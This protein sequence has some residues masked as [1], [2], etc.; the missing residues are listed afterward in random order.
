[1]DSVFLLTTGNTYRG[2][3]FFMMAEVCSRWLVVYSAVPYLDFHWPGH[4]IQYR[5]NSSVIIKCPRWVTK[6][7][8]ILSQLSNLSIHVRVIH[9][10]GW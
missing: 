8:S 10:K 1:M 7:L 5:A 3:I 2:Q 9:I 6:I 4:K